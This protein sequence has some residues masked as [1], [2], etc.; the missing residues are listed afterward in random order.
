MGAFLLIILIQSIIDNNK[1]VQNIALN[2]YIVARIP[3][4]QKIE[5]NGAMNIAI[6]I[7]NDSLFLLKRSFALLQERKQ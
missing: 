6:H 7:V 4:L 2:R 3:S 5:I 1:P